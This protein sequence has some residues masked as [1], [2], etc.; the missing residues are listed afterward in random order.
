MKR[1][2]ER[3]S[4]RFSY[5]IDARYEHASTLPSG[6]SEGETLIAFGMIDVLLLR[7]CRLA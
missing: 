7:F 1:F 3:N 5:G 4:P 6:P 2:F